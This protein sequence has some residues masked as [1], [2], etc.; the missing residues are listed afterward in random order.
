MS[1]KNVTEGLPSGREHGA[2]VANGWLLLH[3]KL[4]DPGPQYHCN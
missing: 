2:S 3:P 4:P 1:Y